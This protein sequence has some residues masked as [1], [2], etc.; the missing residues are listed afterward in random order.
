MVKETADIIPN[1]E[2]ASDAE[3]FEALKDFNVLGHAAQHPVDIL[4]FNTCGS[5]DDGK[6]TLIGRLLYDSKSLM[7]D[8]LE[9]LQRSADITG[10]GQ[11][12]L[13]NLTDGLRA[14]REQGITIDVAYRYFATPRRKFIIADTPG[15]VQYTRNMVTGASTANIS[16]VLVDAR[17]GV[18]E[19]SRRHTYLASLLRIPHLVVAVNKMDLVSW[20][21][22]RFLEIRD[23]FEEFLPRLDIKDVKFIPLS[24]LHG[25]NVVELSKNMPWYQ[26][27]TFLG[28]LETVHIASDWNLNGLRFPV[29]WVN[30][31]KNP[32]DPALHDFRGLSG[33]ISGGIVK[34]GQQIMVL[35][36]GLKSTVKEIW[37]YDGPRTEAF[38]PQ[39]T[40]LLLE[41]DIDVS[42][43]DMLVGLDALPGMATE[44]SARVCWMHSRPL[45]SGR[46]YFLKQTTQTVQAVVT[47]LESRINIDT[48]DPEP[49]PAELSMNGIGQIK[50]LTSK[51]IVFDGYITNRLTGSLILIEPSTN[52]TVAAG[53]LLPPVES[54]KPEYQDFVI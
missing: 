27:P 49:A 50:L 37:T 16:V 22:E 44:L 43:G 17:L 39:A 33:Q 48:F 5:V 18:I 14:E 24:A 47:A 8:Q 53:M 51:P 20:S 30:R 12:N 54:V 2:A 21:E 52:A 28:H 15:H 13:A 10:G 40:T 26:G 38:C 11:I 41:D 25:D 1:H 4:R 6:S 3:R 19:Q 45:Q 9:A 23:Q 42:R 46:K 32:T 34:Q 7:E 35:P 31:P 36:R 29:Q